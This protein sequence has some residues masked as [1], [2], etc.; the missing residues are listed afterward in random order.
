MAGD[1]ATR[2]DEADEP[3]RG[4]VPGDALERRPPDE[5]A[6]LVELDDAAEAGLE[7]VRASIELVAVQGH[8]GLE[9]QRVA[10]AEA[11]GHQPDGPPAAEQRVPDLAEPSTSTKTS[12]PSSPV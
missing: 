2:D 7:R 3:A 12:N 9:A 5:V 6:R 8:A 4:A 10:R 11:D 1:A